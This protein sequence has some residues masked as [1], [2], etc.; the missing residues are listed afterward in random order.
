M[1]KSRLHGSFSFLRGL[2]RELLFFKKRNYTKTG[3]AP[4]SVQVYIKL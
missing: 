3:A 1:K 2:R 4:F